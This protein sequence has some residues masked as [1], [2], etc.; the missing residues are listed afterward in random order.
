MIF[1]SLLNRL[2]ATLHLNN[3]QKE[4]ETLKEEEMIPKSTFNDFW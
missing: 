3:L 1:C 4:K 2:H